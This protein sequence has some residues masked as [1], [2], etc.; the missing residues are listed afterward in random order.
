[1]KK[2]K[3]VKIS[4]WAAHATTIVSVALVLLIIGII[5]LVTTAARRESHRLKESLEIS[6]IMADSVS[7]DGA[8]AT[9][10]LLESRPFCRNPRLITKEQALAAWKDD[11]GEDLEALFGVNPLS[12]E[13]SFTMPA[14]WSEPDSLARME[15]ELRAVAGVEDVAMPGG[16]LVA[17]M[18]SNIGRFSMILGVIAVVLLI[19][20]F[21]LINNTVHLTIYARRFI[22]HTMQLVGATNSF[23]RRPLV[24]RNCCAGM[25]AGLI[26]AAVLGGVLLLA[27]RAGFNE[28][29]Q[30]IGWEAYAVIAVGL[31]VIGGGI[32]ALTASIATTRYLRKDYSE[33][34]H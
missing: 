13:I 17:T 32:C 20:S 22:I 12:P 2:Q 27:P 10:R 28:M 19:I 23:I 8:Q 25:L 34:F 15:K 24:W 3:E 18:N 1:M 31:I 30:M 5:A 6:V 7:N 4:Y 14:A 16:D 21:V 11:T 29:G 33:L 26:A 9:L